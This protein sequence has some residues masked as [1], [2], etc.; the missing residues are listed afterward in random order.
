[1]SM[2]SAVDRRLLMAARTRGHGPRRE[3]AILAY[4]RLG[5]HAA[6][7]LALGAG[8]ALL[9]TALGGAACR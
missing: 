7:W 6:C 3:R 2:L 9:G 5:E 8:G 1:M 4:S